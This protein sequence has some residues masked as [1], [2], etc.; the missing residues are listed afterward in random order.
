MS[1][2]KV[3]YSMISAAPANAFD[4]G[5][6]SDGVTDDSAAIQLAIDSLGSAGGL[7]LIPPDTIWVKSSLTI[8]SNVALFDLA[9]AGKTLHTTTNYFA[10]NNLGLTLGAPATGTRLFMSDS[11][12]GANYLAF[13]MDTG[14]TPAT[15]VCAGG[16]GSVAFTDS[17]NNTKASINV[18]NSNTNNPGFL[19]GFNAPN[20]GGFS[21]VGDSS[22]GNSLG[23]RLQDTSVGGVDWQLYV[24]GGATPVWGLYDVTNGEN[25]FKFTKTYQQFYKPVIMPSYVVGSLPSA[26]TAYQR[27]F[28]VDATATTF[29]SIVAG[30]G[31][32][33]VPVFSDG[34]NWRI[35]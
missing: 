35:G 1:L 15:Y 31:S 4:F 22:L 30:G 11:G 14:P 6:V 27:A 34:T 3:T 21:A 16:G 17:G 8:P 29:N 13:G 20:N 9:A 12:T 28:V 19:A 24:S 25:I 23:V 10:F 5:A 33:K 7:V 26:S 18:N 2:T 32:N